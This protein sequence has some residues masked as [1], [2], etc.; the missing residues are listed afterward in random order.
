MNEWEAEGGGEEGAD[1]NQRT[2][3][4]QE[5]FK[6]KTGKKPSALQRAPA[7]NKQECDSAERKRE[8]NTF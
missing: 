4:R 3:S 6:G 5:F 2:K 7:Q 1:A 8:K